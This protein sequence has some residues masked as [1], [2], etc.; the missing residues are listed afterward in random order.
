MDDK[1]K[2]ISILVH[3]AFRNF[4]VKFELAATSFTSCIFLIFFFAK[5]YLC[6]ET[7]WAAQVGKKLLY[8]TPLI[9][10]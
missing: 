5:R 9:A 2:T 10:G 1:N 3:T 6:A 8:S 4:R 7:F